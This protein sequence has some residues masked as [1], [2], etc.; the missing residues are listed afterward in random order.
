[1]SQRVVRMTEQEAKNIIK[2]EA[3]TNVRKHLEAIQVAV[4]VL[5]E[6]CT[7]KDIWKWAEGNVGK[8]GGTGEDI[9]DTVH[10]KWNGRGN[11]C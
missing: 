6:N 2:N 10:Q 5:G 8:G 1:M 3:Y 7:M 9:Q 11:A 4:K